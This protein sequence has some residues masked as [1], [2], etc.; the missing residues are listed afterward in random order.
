M[1]IIVPLPMLLGL[2]GARRHE[3]H[4]AALSTTWQGL[5]RVCAG[6]LVF[7]GVILGVVLWLA[8]PTKD[9]LL[10]RFRRPLRLSF[11]G[12]GY[13][14]GIRLALGV[15]A[16]VVLSILVTSKVMTMDSVQT[17]ANANRPDVETVVNV[18]ALK[19]DRIYYWLTLTFVSF[20][21]AGLREELWRVTSLTTL[22]RMWPR[23]FGSRGGEYLGVV[24]TSIIFGIGHLPQGLLAVGVTA[25]IGIFL[26]AIMV[27]HRSI[28]PAVIAHGFFDATSF[29]LIPLVLEKLPSTH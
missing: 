13:S 4:Q 21:V 9:E 3:S 1:L 6:E 24:L 22:R 8:K 14:V 2:L 28:W 15:L 11:L 19:N 7:F 29:A 18:K 23:A 10:L 16:A 5:L 26:G 17:F 27:F 20:V 25:V 12:V